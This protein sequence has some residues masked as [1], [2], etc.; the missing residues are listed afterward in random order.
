MPVCDIDYANVVWLEQ[1]L[2]ESDLIGSADG[3]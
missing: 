3:A 1:L 2:P